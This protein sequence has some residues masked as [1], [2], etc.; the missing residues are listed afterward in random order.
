MK[1]FP[2]MTGEKG[3]DL[4]DYFAAKCMPIVHKMLEHNYNIGL[5]DDFE[6]EYDQEEFDS[7]A[8]IAYAM[9]DAMIKAR[10]E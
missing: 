9:A 6:W 8:D 10:E 4:R 5:N 7:M 2:N 3:M 1:A